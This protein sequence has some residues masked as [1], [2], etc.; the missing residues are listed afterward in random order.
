MS[1]EQ[2]YKLTPVGKKKTYIVVEKNCFKKTQEKHPEEIE[3]SEL[4][5]QVTS[6]KTMPLTD[7]GTVLLQ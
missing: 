6:D 1:L 7:Q 2:A 3:E 4:Q 5:S